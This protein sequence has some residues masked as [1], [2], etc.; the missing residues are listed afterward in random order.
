VT[1]FEGS[2]EED[3]PEPFFKANTPKSTKRATNAKARLQEI[4]S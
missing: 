1:V 2:Q 4:E 3:L